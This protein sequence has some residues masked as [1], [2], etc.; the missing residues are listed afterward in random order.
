MILYFI[1]IATV[2]LVNTLLTKLTDLDK[3]KAEI[4]FILKLPSY[5][6]PHQKPLSH[7]VLSS[8]KQFIRRAAPIIFMVS[9]V[10]RFLGCFPQNGDLQSSYLAVIGQWIEPIFEP[11]DQAGVMVWRYSRHFQR[12]R[13][14]LGHQVLYLGAKSQTK[15]QQDQLRIFNKTVLPQ[16]QA[17]D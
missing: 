10:I 4:P 17:L 15:I 11:Q 12:A 7:R 5:R 8:A 3:Y 2:L 1:G 16:V 14:S 6:L 9:V 13:Y